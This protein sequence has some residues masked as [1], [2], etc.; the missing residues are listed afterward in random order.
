MLL[1]PLA[2]DTIYMHLQYQCKE[3]TKSW[4]QFTLFHSA[5]LLIVHMLPAKQVIMWIT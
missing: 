1:Q 2:I 5:S 4:Q 3:E